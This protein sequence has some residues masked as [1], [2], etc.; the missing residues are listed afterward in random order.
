MSNQPEHI[1]KMNYDNIFLRCAIVGFL[2]FMRNRFTWYNESEEQGKYEV[3][4]PIH[5]SLTGDHRYIVDAFLDDM[6]DTRVNMNTD[7]IPRGVVTLTN[8][9]VKPDEFTNPNI[10]LNVK[11]EIDDE[12]VQVAAQVKSV[13]VKLT[14]QLDVITNSEI[15]VFKAWQ[16][17]MEGL[18]MYK[19]FT[20]DYRRFP[21]NAVFNFVGDMDNPIA[22]EYNFGT[23]KELIKS[24]YNFEVN[25]FFPIFDENNEQYAN[26]VSNWIT[27]IWQ[28]TSTQGTGTP[29]AGNNTT[30]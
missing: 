18:W 4:L 20:F 22:R 24:T 1:Y 16:I 3:K 19:Y 12:L 17:Y 28:N 7:S 9:A 21:I 26:N 6:P 15:D 2:G 25:T 5:Y 23:S 8:W 10:W 11:K 13:P 27:N 29:P 14:F 30:I